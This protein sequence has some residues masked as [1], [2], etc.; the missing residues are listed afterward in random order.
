[1][2]FFNFLKSDILRPNDQKI[3]A[4]IQGKNNFTY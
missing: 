3:L 1:M 2:F 4:K